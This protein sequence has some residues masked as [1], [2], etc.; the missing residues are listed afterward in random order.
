M[1]R[2]KYRFDPSTNRYT[3]PHMVSSNDMVYAILDVTTLTFEIYSITTNQVVQTGSGV[4]LNMLKK[5]TKKA[6]RDLGVSFQDEVR[7]ANT[8]SIERA[9]A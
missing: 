6:L 4:S 2:V 8:I 7:M 5:N 9:S 3:T 1:T